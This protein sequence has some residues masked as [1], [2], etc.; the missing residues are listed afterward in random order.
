MTSSAA[1]DDLRTAAPPT[2]HLD[3]TEAVAW[4]ADFD[5]CLAGRHGP[6]WRTRAERE[7]LHGY[8]VHD[9]R[10][11]LAWALVRSFDAA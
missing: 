8:E 7:H 1:G 5:D 3:R 4:A 2:D 9:A 10:F 6:A 11:A